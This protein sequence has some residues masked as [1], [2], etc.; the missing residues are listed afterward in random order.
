MPPVS[1]WPD[2]SL[3]EVLDDFQSR[4]VL[5]VTYGSVLGNPVLRQGLF[6]TLHAHEVVYTNNLI[7]HF[8]CHFD[9]LA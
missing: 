4:E 5:H 9:L 6:D 3:P 2:P 1:N 8:G 7:D